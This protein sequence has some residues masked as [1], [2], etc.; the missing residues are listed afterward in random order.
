MPSQ[1]K[2]FWIAKFAAN[3]RRDRR[4]SKMLEATG[5]SVLT[6]WECELKDLDALRNR[7]AKEL[8]DQ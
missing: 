8:G 6:V 7:I 4:N 1:N 2:P 5:W 3:R